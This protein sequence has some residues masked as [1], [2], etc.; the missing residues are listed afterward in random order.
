[1]TA[2]LLGIQLLGLAVEIVGIAEIASRPLLSA[3]WWTLFVLGAAMLITRVRSRFARSILSCGRKAILPF[4]IIGTAIVIDLLIAIAPS[5]KVDEIRY[6][7]L[8][9]SRIVTDGALHF[10]REPW[11]G[12][13]FPDMLFQIS[14]APTHA[15]GYPDA[16]NVVSW[17]ISV[18]LLWFAWQIIRAQRKPIAWSALWVGSLCVG[19]YPAIWHVS[20]GPHAMGDL[21]MAAAVIAFCTREHL[22]KSLSPPAY[23]LMLSVLLLSAG[24][25]KIS[26]LPLCAAI[27]CLGILPLLRWSDARA[28]RNIL[29]A[30]ALP[31]IVFFLPIVLWTWS[32][33]GS[34]FGPV[35]SG[36]FGTEISPNWSGEIQYIRQVNQLPLLTIGPNFLAAYSP[37]VW[38]GIIGAIFFSSLPTLIRAELCLLLVLQCLLIYWLLPHDPRFLGG[39]HFG[40]LII[41]AAFVTPYI[42]ELATLR[43]VLLSSALLL[44]PWLG[45]QIY[46][47]KQFF[48]V[49]LGLEKLAFYE[50]YVAFYKDYVQL[51]QLLPNDTVILVRHF[52]TSPVYAPRPIF[53]NSADLPKGKQVVLFAPPNSDS[54]ISL[55]DY[56]RGKVL[57]TNPRAVTRT[58]RT[59]GRD[60][61]VGPLEVLQ[62]V[63]RSSR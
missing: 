48:P 36:L 16:A 52:D 61:L 38:L 9:P 15:I 60:S 49:A 17:A 57:Y 46:Y 22:V 50:R 63:A 51:N 47:A 7:M 34:P 6:H 24:T 29:G 59:P 41:F 45:T 26:L 2:I 30:I 40:L 5:T 44:I 11:E 33:S 12:A 3:I 8:L 55:G 28:C 18:T 10:Y 4:A 20:A 58:F 23:G 54:E 62:L 37:L 25:S 32:N 1:M 39:L 14:S 19:L 43:F 56:K 21:A 31:W 42:Q 13:I 27:L 53:F 35:L